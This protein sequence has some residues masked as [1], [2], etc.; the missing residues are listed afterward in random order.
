MKKR[1]SAL[2]RPFRDGAENGVEDGGDSAPLI[3]V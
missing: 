1:M 3:Q 2:T